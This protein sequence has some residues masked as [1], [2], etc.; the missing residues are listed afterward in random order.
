MV[1][2]ID[3]DFPGKEIITVKYRNESFYQFDA[4]SRGTA[5]GVVDLGTT[6]RDCLSSH[7]LSEEQID[8]V[9]NHINQWDHNS[10][11]EFKF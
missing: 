1:R 8:I 4:Y 5:C 11:H 10:D 2:S 9:I 3:F 6:G 7:G